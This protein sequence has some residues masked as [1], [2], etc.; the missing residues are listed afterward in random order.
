MRTLIVVCVSLAVSVG[1]RWPIRSLRRSSSQRRPMAKQRKVKRNQEPP[2]GP[3]PSPTLGNESGPANSEPSSPPHGG[4]R[5][6]YLLIRWRHDFIGLMVLALYGL[7]G[8]D[9]LGHYAGGRCKFMKSGE[10]RLFQGGIC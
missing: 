10:Q 4:R 2:F 6:G 9:S 5:V 8:L 3:T 7:L 1:C